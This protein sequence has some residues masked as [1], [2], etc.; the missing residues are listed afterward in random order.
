MFHSLAGNDLLHGHFHLLAIEGVL[1]GRVEKTNTT[2]FK[3][4]EETPFYDVQDL[5]QNIDLSLGH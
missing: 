3:P 5:T 2:A 4:D 1:P